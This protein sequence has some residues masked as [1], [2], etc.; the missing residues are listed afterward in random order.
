MY[1]LKDPRI[2]SSNSTA[3]N[4]DSKARLGLGR[5]ASAM[6]GGGY[7][8]EKY[9]QEPALNTCGRYQ[10]VDLDVEITTEEEE[11]EVSQSI[12][13]SHQPPQTLRLGAETIQFMKRWYIR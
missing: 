11:E 12:T 3:I 2:C 7:G 4:K 9:V 6:L 1:K 13:M 10:T 8:E 5:P